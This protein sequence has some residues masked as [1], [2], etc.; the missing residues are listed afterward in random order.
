[1]STDFTKKTIH[2]FYLKEY[3]IYLE[4]FALNRKKRVVELLTK[5]FLTVIWRNIMLKIA[6]HWEYNTNQSKHTVKIL[7]IAFYYHH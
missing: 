1:M 3:G 6:I 5:N 7:K 2:D 4:H